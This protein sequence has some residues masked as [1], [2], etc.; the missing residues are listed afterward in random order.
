MK[1][2][3]EDLEW[4]GGDVEIEIQR[5]P[6]RVLISASGTGRMQASDAGGQ[7]ARKGLSERHS[8]QLVVYQKP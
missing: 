8:G 2:A 7:A 4:P 5:E 3:V 6:Q 1:E